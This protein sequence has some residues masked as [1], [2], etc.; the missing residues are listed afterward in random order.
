MDAETQCNV[1][2]MV[3]DLLTKAEFEQATEF[4]IRLAASE[5][6]GIDLSDSHS[7]QFVRNIIATNKKPPQVST[8]AVKEPPQELNKV[9]GV[10]CKNDD[11]DK[12]ICELSSNR[13]VTVGD[14][15]GRT[16]VSIREYFLKD[17]K[18]LPTPKG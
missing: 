11:S 3:M 5:R 14:Y 12:V 2:E 4:T 8:E 18:Q 1:E 6:L 7:R 15:K 9:A 17:G 13:K 16:L 10:K